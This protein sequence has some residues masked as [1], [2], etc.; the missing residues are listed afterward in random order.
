MKARSVGLRELKTHLSKYIS[1][2]KEG[3]TLLI[4][5]R[6]KVVGRITPVQAVSTADPL[7][8]AGLALWSG[9]K[10]LPKVKPLKT[11]G[12]QTVTDLLLEERR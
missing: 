12:D 7:I 5:V 8:E 3:N 11:K 9:K 10:F 2:V 6:G 4:S 1:E